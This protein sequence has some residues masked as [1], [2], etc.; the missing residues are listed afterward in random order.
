MP[1]EDDSDRITELAKQGHV[2][3]ASLTPAE[4]QELASA[5]LCGLYDEGEGLKPSEPVPN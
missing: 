4:I 5:V 2:N 3:P 1:R